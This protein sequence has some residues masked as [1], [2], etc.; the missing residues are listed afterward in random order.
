M[1]R[2]QIS[3][4]PGPRIL[5]V[6]DEALVAW[7]LSQRL[8]EWGY[9]VCGVS[10]RLA[11]ALVKADRHRPHLALVDVNLQGGDDGVAAARMLRDSYGTQV[12][13]VTGMDDPDTR[14]RIAAVKPSGCVLKPYSPKD[15][16]SAIERALA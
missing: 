15:L 11:D 16:R 1:A 6:E 13:F 2:N 8:S 3:E 4:A 5:V 7:E 12:L 10:A 9:D 14:R